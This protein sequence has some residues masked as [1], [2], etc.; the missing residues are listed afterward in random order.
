MTPHELAISI[1]EYQKRELYQHRERITAAYMGAYL[2]RVKRM[3]KLEKLIG[4][5]PKKKKPM[6]DRQMLDMIRLLNKKIGGKE[7]GK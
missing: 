2:Q 4:D 5:Q 6:T 1:E 7:V 3:P